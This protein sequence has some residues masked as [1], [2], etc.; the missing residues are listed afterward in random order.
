MIVFAPMLGLAV[1]VSSLVGRYLGG[2]QPDLA[3]RSVHSAVALSLAYMALCGLV[4]VFG[5]GALLAPYAAGADPASFPRI[6]AIA[7]V[8]LRFVALYSIFD[9]MNLVYAAG[10]R[11]AGDTLYPLGLTV[12]LAWVA[13]LGPALVGCVVLGA[14]VYFAWATASAYVVLLGLLL[15]RR[16]RLGRWKTMRVIERRSPEMEAVAGRT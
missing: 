2:D 4:Y 3:E 15:R 8:L 12:V 13:M 7:T 10:L 1:A 6:G 5:A 16:F 14:G 11:G 9:M